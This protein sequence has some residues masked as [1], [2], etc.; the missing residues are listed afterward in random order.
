VTFNDRS[1]CRFIESTPFRRVLRGTPM[2][3]GPTEVPVMRE[4]VDGSIV[5]RASHDGYARRFG[6]LHERTLTLSPDGGRLD[7]EDMFF[8]ADGLTQPSSSHDEFAVRFHLHPSIKANR[9]TDGHG[10]MLV[11]ANKEVWTF[12]AYEDRIDLEESVYLAGA[13][14]PRRTVQIV[15]YGRARN[16]PRVFWTFLHA[17]PPASALIGRRTRGQEPELP[18]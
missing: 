6:I 18:L 7:G 11:T 16:V 14:G 12:S 9:L 4:V 15:I 5:M 17:P 8:P 10:V 3:E 1:S 13:D 2:L